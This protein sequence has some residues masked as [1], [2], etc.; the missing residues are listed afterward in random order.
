MQSRYSDLSKIE[1]I[2]FVGSVQNNVGSFH[3][4][5]FFRLLAGKHFEFGYFQG[6]ISSLGYLSLYYAY[7]TSNLPVVEGVH[8]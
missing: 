2:I 3:M 6:V 4:L 8:Y 7:G 5:I 1:R